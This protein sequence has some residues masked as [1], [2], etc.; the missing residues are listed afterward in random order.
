MIVRKTGEG[1]YNGEA[2]NLKKQ[3]TTTDDV[4]KGLV[5]WLCAQLKKPSHPSCAIP[6][7][8]NCLAT[9]LKEPMVRCLRSLFVQADGVKLLIRLILLASTLQS[10]QVSLPPWTNT[11]VTH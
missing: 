1:H 8:I 6:T 10:M 11:G 4:L 5:E 2:S 7:A 3:L 9:L